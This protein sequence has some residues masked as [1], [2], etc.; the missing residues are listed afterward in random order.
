M[1]LDH[2][3]NNDLKQ[4]KV[5]SDRNV[6]INSFESTHVKLKIHP[7]FDSDLQEGDNLDIL[8][9]STMELISTS[10]VLPNRIIEVEIQ[11]FTIDKTILPGSQLG[12]IK[13][14]GSTTKSVESE[15]GV[16]SETKSNTEKS[17][18]E[19]DHQ[20][21]LFT[22]D[23]LCE[24]CN[25]RSVTELSGIFSHATVKVYSQ[26]CY[27]YQACKFNQLATFLKC[28]KL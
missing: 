23:E 5:L 1:K 22:L 27:K 18:I 26:T 3:N 17:D 19:D 15:S 4:L 25:D 24:I 13:S 2:Y 20:E 11:T 10:K 16:V 14:Y 21:K 28:S 12:W 6:K 9:G 8:I 7:R